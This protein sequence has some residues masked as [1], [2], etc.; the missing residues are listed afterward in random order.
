MS[1]I[2]R[3]ATW[4]ELFFDLIFVVA[5]A[6]ATHAL[7]HVHHGHLE[8]VS[9]LKYVLIMLLLWWVWKSYIS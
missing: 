7:G 1:T 3:K 6:Q 2:V 4:L 8:A 9:Y 5:V